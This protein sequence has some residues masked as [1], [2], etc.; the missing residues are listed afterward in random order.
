MRRPT[1]PC[2]GAEPGGSPAA[3][4]AGLELA[5]KRPGQRRAPLACAARGARPA[6]RRSPRVPWALREGR[7]AAATEPHR[8]SAGGQGGQPCADSVGA[9]AGGWA[10]AARSRP[11]IPPCAQD[12]AACPAHR[13]PRAPPATV[14]ASRVRP[15]AMPPWCCT[16][17]RPRRSGSRP[18][19][20]S[21]DGGSVRDKS[22]ALTGRRDWYGQGRRWGACQ[23]TAGWRGTGTPG[24]T[25]G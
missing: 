22:W 6:D 8:R 3:A 12:V 11:R 7:L 23:A 2:A 24:R 14:R 19:P 10:P 1:W 18:A 15:R 5:T 25:W 4:A 21:G 20:D 17:P 16:G 9:P 13:P